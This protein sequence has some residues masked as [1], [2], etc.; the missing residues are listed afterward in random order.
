MIK[1]CVS[2]WGQA[3]AGPNSDLF[4][5]FLQRRVSD[6]HL[7]HNSIHTTL[8]EYIYIYPETWFGERRAVEIRPHVCDSW[9]I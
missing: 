8:Q 7:A 4:I 1:A 3:A 9:I 2:L 6:A 5:Y